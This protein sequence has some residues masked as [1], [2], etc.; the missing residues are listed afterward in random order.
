MENTGSRHSL[1]KRTRTISKSA[2]IDQDFEEI[3]LG[4]IQ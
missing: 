1:L 4:K 2:S 3:E